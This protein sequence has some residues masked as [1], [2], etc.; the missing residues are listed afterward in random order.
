MK[1]IYLMLV[2]VLSGHLLSAQC[3]SSEIFAVEDANAYCFEI[4]G[5]VRYVYSNNYPD[6]DDDFN[7]DF[8]TLTAG[9]YEYY[10]CAY[11]EMADAFTPLYEETETTVGCEYNY[12]FGVSINGV[13]YDPNSAVTFVNTE[14]NSNNIEWH[15]EATSTE[16]SIG[17][18]MGQLNGGHLNASGIYHY[19][20]VP[21]DYFTNDL[22][23][24]GSDHSSI[25]GYAADGFPIYY[26]YIYTDSED[27]LSAITS[28]S[29][30]Y[31]LKS[32]DRPGDGSTAPDGPY[33]G[34]YY[35]DYEYSSANTILDE[36]NGRYGVTPDYP[37]GT[38]YYVITD[39]Y[40]YIPRCFKGTHVDDSFRV[41]PT[42]A[43]S[44]SASTTSTN[45]AAAVTGCVDPF[46]DNYNA[47]ATVD[48]GS[49]SYS[50]IT[51]SGSWSNGTGPGDGNH[52]TIS[53]D[54]D[55]SADGKFSCDNLTISSGASLTVDTE[56]ALLV[57][58]NLTN[59]GSLI[60][61]SGGS[62]IT[63][64]GTIF[65]GND[66]VIKRTTRY[67][68]GKYSFVGTPVN[69]T[70]SLTGSDLGS[71]VYSYNETTAYGGD[72]GLSRWENAA[73]DELVPG[74]GYAQAFQQELTFSG[75][76]NDGTITV[77]GT[78]TDRTN[79]N[80]EGWV[81]VSN[82][83]PSAISVAAFLSEN[84]H[85]T[86][87]VYFWD[88]NNSQSARGSNADY[89][90]ANAIATTQTSQAGNDDRYNYH[91]GSGQGFFVKLSSASN[92]DVVFTEDMRVSD[93]NSDGNFF[94]SASA[95]VPVIRINLTDEDGLFKQ[96]VIGQIDGL[97]STGINKMY[98]AAAINSE[99]DEAIY[100][101]KS[102]KPL[103]I[104]G[105]DLES[106]SI[107]LGINISEIGSYQL[108]AEVENG[109]ALELIDRLTGETVS[110]NEDY[111]FTSTA[112]QHTDRFALQL[113][114]KV[115]GA[116]TDV[117]QIYAAE[118]ILYVRLLDNESKMITV[119]DLAGN[120]VK[121]EMVSGSQEISLAELK[122]GIYIVTDGDQRRKIIKN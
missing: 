57:Y 47:S 43:C 46:S 119:F 72:Q 55:F 26:K 8:F 74:K 35:E 20:A 29:S 50:T 78:F 105:A 14:D 117:H 85:L 1:S 54:Y 73:A 56:E 36:C 76:P 30:G 93:S 92:L 19:H 33:D 101:Y 116:G 25:V 106:G 110:L 15:V 79:D 34:N 67:A 80:V 61:E 96:T 84:A 45:C 77:T 62:L 112:G 12:E 39:E 52:V 37:Y 7:Q 16:N 86:G 100:S 27:A 70:A 44:P 121:S 107:D 102:G 95:N 51:W 103:A 63:Y 31:T 104:Q 9:D 59:S 2:A 99:F 69:Q 42:A 48:D 75:T 11:P 118:D 115:L 10:M 21:T 18:S 5:N 53:V 32:G 94:R 88:D 4:D 87:A 68:D 89:I 65:S 111:S 113:V 24:D 120:R 98:D 49:C 40:P 6:H 22:G 83:Y 71:N 97:V 60:V 64:D 122:D 82:P 81:L 41:G 109:Y 114:N 3:N 108:S 23:I 38:Y 28:A 58:G 13:R 90:V 66:V 17:V 91:I